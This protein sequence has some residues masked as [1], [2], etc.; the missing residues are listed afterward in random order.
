[1]AIVIIIYSTVLIGVLLWIGVEIVAGIHKIC[2]GLY[3]LGETLRYIHEDLLRM[4]K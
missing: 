1:M 4:R 3:S 2:R